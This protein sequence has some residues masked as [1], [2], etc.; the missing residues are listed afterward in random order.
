MCWPGSYADQSVCCNVVFNGFCLLCVGQ[1]R[2]LT[3]QC[4]VTLSSTGFA[5]CVLARSYTDQYVCCYVVFYIV[6]LA[7]CRP[8]PQADQADDRAGRHRGE[9]DP[10][11]TRPRRSACH[12]GQSPLHHSGLAQRPRRLQQ[13]RSRGLGRILCLPVHR[14][15]LHGQQHQL[16]R[17]AGGLGRWMMNKNKQDMRLIFSLSLSARL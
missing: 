14:Q 4:V 10:P 8:G 5:C 6:W 12:N 17:H 15:L 3:D 1:D 13:Q 2:T 11:A 7:L 16:R 9:D